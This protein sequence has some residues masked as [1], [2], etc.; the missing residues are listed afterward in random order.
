MR[1]ETNDRPEDA[2]SV[3]AV[4]M[5]FTVHLSSQYAFYIA[6]YFAPVRQ[7]SMD[8]HSLLSIVLPELENPFLNVTKLNLSPDVVT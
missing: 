2:S 8:H 5:L 7:R 3:E 4:C 1:K 6:R